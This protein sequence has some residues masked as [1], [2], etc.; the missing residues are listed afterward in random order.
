MR[1][2]NAGDTMMHASAVSV[3]GRAAMAV[4]PPGSG[5]S[6]TVLEL[7]SRG[8]TLVADDQTVLRRSANAIEVSPPPQL[9]G[10]IEARGVG[11]L[12][13]QY[14]E[15]AQLALIVDLAKAETERL[16][17]RRCRNILGLDIDVIHGRGRKGLAAALF[18]LLQ[19]ARAD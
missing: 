4:G 6:A 1:L 12:R 2:S 5:K 13:L 15:A 18:A 7:I 17:E 14:A 16:P 9:A 8:G 10:L 11:L 19:G 3:G